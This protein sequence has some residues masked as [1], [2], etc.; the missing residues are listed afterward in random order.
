VARIPD[1]QLSG[2]VP[3]VFHN[4]LHRALYNNPE[5]SDAWSVLGRAAHTSSHLPQRTREL[6]ILRIA[7]MLKSDVEW[8]QHLRLATGAG[9]TLDEAR[10]LR[11]G[12]PTE[13]G[14]DERAAVEFGEAV[15]RCT[16]D[17]D[18]WARAGAHFTPVQLLEIAVLAGFYGLASRVALALGVEVDEGLSPIADFDKLSQ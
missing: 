5:L 3:E 12:T 8:A 6:V 2:D 17:D 15:E 13:F 16:V 10:S 14:P 4:N 1:A 18:L 11:D 9:V 7:A